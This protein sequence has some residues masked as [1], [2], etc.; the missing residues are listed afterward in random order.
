MKKIAIMLLA[1]L[2]LFAF[3][4]CDDKTPEVPAASTEEI[5]LVADYIDA[6]DQDAVLTAI[7]SE[8]AGVE[9]GDQAE[10][11]SYTVT[12]TNFNGFKVSATA[13]TNPKISGKVVLTFKGSDGQPD[14]IVDVAAGGTY[15][16]KVDNV[17]LASDNKADVKISLDANG[18]ISEATGTPAYNID[19]PKVSDVKNF[20]VSFDGTEK[21]ATWEAIYKLT[22][23]YVE[24]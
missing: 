20:K 8:S 15:T 21:S 16:V 5:Q 22:D 13:F 17:T 14:A 4:A 12:F 9:V 6:L 24:E 1:A 23:N 10:D 19:F 11:G 3:V 18:A 2:M 7:A